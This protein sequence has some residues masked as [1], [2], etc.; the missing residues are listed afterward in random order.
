MR[1]PTC[2]AATTVTDTRQA[3]STVRRRRVCG[4]CKKRFTTIEVCEPVTAKKA[5]DK[6]RTLRAEMAN[7]VT[8]L[9]EMDAM[10]KELGE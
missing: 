2:N 3:G 5:G 10:L 1:C 7:L 4:K 8:I 9:R 6:T